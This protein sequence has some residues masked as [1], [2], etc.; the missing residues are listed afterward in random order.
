MSAYYLLE[1][2]IVVRRADGANIPPDEDN[3]DYQRYLEW[4]AAGNTPDPSENPQ[5]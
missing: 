3:G 1:N 2:G 4:L 5:G